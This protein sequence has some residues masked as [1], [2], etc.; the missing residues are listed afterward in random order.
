MKKSILLVM[1][2]LLSVAGFSQVSWN[3]KV[4]MN[5][6]N[7]TGDLD[8]SAKVGVKLGVGMEY[9]FND[10]WLLQPSLF[11]SQKGAKFSA[12]VSG[13][14]ADVKFN[15]MNFELPIMMAAR[16]NVA[17]NTNIVV[18]AGPYMAYGV[19]GKTR[20]KMRIGG[21][22]TDIKENTFGS[23]AFD[24]FDAGLGVGVAAEFGRIIVGLDGQFGLVK[25]MDMNI[26]SNP[27]NI[28]CAITLGYKF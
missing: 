14:E 6:S 24:R 27:K 15:A 12:T 5:I 13:D 2:A 25:L 17:N 1:F 18:S 9:A 28:N 3:A 16:F 10:T 11:L 19:G 26:D 23:D 7:F 22:K 8:V 20:T 4:G 21:A